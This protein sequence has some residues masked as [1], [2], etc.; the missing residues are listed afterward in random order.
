MEDT[1]FEVKQKFYEILMSRP[2]EERFLMCAEMYDSA[3]VIA[4]SNMPENLPENEQK[5]FIYK[6]IYDENFPC[7][8]PI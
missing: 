2:E 1:T 3:R 4:L 6:K 5:Q 7:D 8:F